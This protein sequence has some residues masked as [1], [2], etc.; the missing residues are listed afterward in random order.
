MKQNIDVLILCGGKGTRLKK[1]S[2]DTPK[3]L[4]RIGRRPFLDI[5]LSHLQK[6][7]L[8]RFILGIG[9]QAHIIKEYYQT[10][11][12][13]GTEIIFS[14]EDKPLGTGG[15]VKK[16]KKYIKSDPF[17][18]LNGDS[19]SEFNADDFLT[20]YKQKDAKVLILLKKVKKKKDFGSITSDSSSQITS[21]IEKK[22][23]LSGSFVNGGVYLFSSNIFSKM[24]KK[25]SFSLE[26]DFFPK[27]V[28]KG[29]YGY[30]KSG[31]FID[32]G[33][34]ERYFAANKHFLKN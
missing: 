8:K 7:G 3:S 32:I 1:I 4:V 26:Y 15:A 16:A 22:S 34:P 17:F 30:K 27:M 13:P 24:P 9:Y 20:F 29:L 23:T 25:N 2:G 12:I 11:I 14:Q 31:F 18:V 28:N 6:A 10:H 5:I 21:F 33:T 19:F